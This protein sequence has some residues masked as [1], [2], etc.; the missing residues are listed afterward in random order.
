MRA[1]CWK[2]WGQIVYAPTEGFRWAPAAVKKYTRRD[3]RRS[4]ESTNCSHF[5]FPCFAFTITSPSSLR[6]F[7]SLT[8]HWN[9]LFFPRL[10][11]TVTFSN[12]CICKI[13]MSATMNMV[14]VGCKKSIHEYDSEQEKKRFSPISFKWF[15]RGSILEFSDSVRTI[16]AFPE[17]EPHHTWN[18]K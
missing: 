15:S 9:H 16:I 2:F 7:G 13:F 8:V 14:Q 4:V 17:A 1:G 18:S 6:F 3:S 11:W 5:C 12:E 10:L